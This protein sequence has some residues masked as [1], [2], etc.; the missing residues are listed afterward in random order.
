M[1]YYLIH[2]GVQERRIF[3]ENQI[4]KFDIPY[5]DVTW[6][7]EPTSISDVPE[8]ICRDKNLKNG[9]IICTYKH[10]L[11]LKDICENEYPLAVIMEDNIEFHQSVPNQIQRYLTDLP[12]DWNCVFDSDTCNLHYIEGKVTK[13]NSVYKKSNK[14]TAQ[15][16]GGS[17][18]ANFILI[19]LETAKILYEN[20]LPF[21]CVDWNY[22]DLLRRFNLN[23]YWTEP[24]NVRHV[25]RPSTAFI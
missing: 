25:G 1:K 4:A 8:N 15:C 17:R 2:G 3:M 24:P 22:N 6:I 20:F 16:G 7:L 21:V 11:A 12:S 10:Y 5:A 23:S 18:G 19:K 14:V 9:A 13:S